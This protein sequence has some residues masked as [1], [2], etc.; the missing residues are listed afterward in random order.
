MQNHEPGKVAVMAAVVLAILCSTIAWI[1]SEAAAQDT[2]YKTVDGLA[3]YLG[4]VP[5]QIVKGH[6]REHSEQTMHG[7]VLSASCRPITL[8]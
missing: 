1:G 2:E 4:V 5:A 8:I 6:P 3:V 7:A